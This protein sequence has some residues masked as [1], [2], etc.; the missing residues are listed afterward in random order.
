MQ[1]VSLVALKYIAAMFCQR[2][3][4]ASASFLVILL[5]FV[6]S[7]CNDESGLCLSNGRP[8]PRMPDSPNCVY[9]FG[10][11]GPL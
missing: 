4:S 10:L 1:Q 5:D 7:T 6:R 9:R 8:L 3:C 2:A 11:E